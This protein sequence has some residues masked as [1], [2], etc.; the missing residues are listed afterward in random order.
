MLK[1]FTDTFEVHLCRRGVWTVERV[2]L[3]APLARELGESEF[4]RSSV[5]GL[6][7]VRIRSSRVTGAVTE[8]LMVE[9]LRSAPPADAVVGTIDEV[10]PCA[11]VEDLLR[12]AARLTL[13]RLFQ[14][15]LRSPEGGGTTCLVSL[16]LS[17]RARDNRDKAT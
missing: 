3:T 4:R 1:R 14:G 7:I 9:R 11:V 13:H 12:P 15:W 16:R 5:D 2:G 10:P 8:D 6:R 17:R